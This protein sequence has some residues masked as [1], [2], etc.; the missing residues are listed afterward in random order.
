MKL[1]IKKINVES[2]GPWVAVLHEETAKKLGAYP[3]DRITIARLRLKKEIN[4]V[5]DVTTTGVKPGQIGL[6]EETFHKLALPEKSHVDITIAEKPESIH[7]IKKKL[8]GHTLSKSEIYQLVKDITDNE[9]SE[10]ELTYFVAATYMKGLSLEETVNLTNAIVETGER[11]KF[12]DKVILDKHC[13]GGVPANRTTMVIV[14]ILASLGYKVPKTSSRAIT[15]ASGTA[16]TMEVLAPVSLSKTKIENMVNKVGGC[17]AWGGAVNLASADDKLIKIRHPLSIDPTGMLLASIMA[18]KK[19]AGATHILIDI[20]CGEGAKIKCDRDAVELKKSFESIAKKLQLKVKVIITDG[21]HPIGN[22]VG[23]ALEAS[24]VISVLKGDGPNDLR[25]KCIMMA[26]E[27]L[28]L[29][30]V[31]DARALVTEEIDS[32]RAWE[33]FKEIVMAQG[34]RKYLRVPKARYFYNVKATKKG[35]VKAIHNKVVAEIARLAGAPEDK[36]AGLYLRVDIREDVTEGMT[37]F[38]V[39]S[40]SKQDIETVKKRLKTLNPISY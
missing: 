8:E 17:I 6:F 4:C 29:A 10:T 19:A 3:S 27:M 23:P 14:P 12:K 33:K 15:S 25:E 24:D 40:N 37:L 35:R 18:K 22:G 30:N 31:K 26:S 28:K 39:Y 13:I 11:L 20:P 34:G 5:L 38:T 21:S 9:F 7:I 2:G 16:D 36:S 32:G 1:E